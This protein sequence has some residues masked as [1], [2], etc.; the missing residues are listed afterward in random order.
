MQIIIYPIANA[1]STA[2]SAVRLVQVDPNNGWMLSYGNVVSLSM[3]VLT[4][5]SDYGVTTYGIY[6][7]SAS[8]PQ[9]YY[10]LLVTYDIDKP[11]MEIS[12][13]SDPFPCGYSPQYVDYFLIY[14]G[15]TSVQTYSSGLPCLIFDSNQMVCKSCVPGYQLSQGQCIYNI[16]CLPRQYSTMVNAFSSVLSVEISTFILEIA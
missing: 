14:Q 16:S 1:L 9:G 7:F 13:Q 12:W 2:D 6:K 10:V 3:D 8:V 15:C 5:L 11:V 4:V